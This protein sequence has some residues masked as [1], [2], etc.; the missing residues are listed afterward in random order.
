MPLEPSAS[1]GSCGACYTSALV[2]PV[3]RE[4]SQA[5]WQLKGASTDNSQ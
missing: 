1:T 3:A 2:Y 5:G 4:L